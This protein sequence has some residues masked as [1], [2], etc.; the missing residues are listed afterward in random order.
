MK[1]KAKTKSHSP[2][3]AKMLPPPPIPAHKKMGF[4][5]IGLYGESGSSHFNLGQNEKEGGIM[6]RQVMQRGNENLKEKVMKNLLVSLACGLI[7][8]AVTFYALSVAFSLEGL[9]VY[10]ISCGVFAA[11]TIVAFGSSCA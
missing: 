5:S 9:P 2:K 8:G 4:N 6:L 3:K 11:A 1:K 10:G 7:A